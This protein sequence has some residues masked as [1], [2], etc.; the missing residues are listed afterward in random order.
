MKALINRLLASVMLLLVVVCLTASSTPG[1]DDNGLDI[2]ECQ[3]P[4]SCPF[5]YTCIN[6]PGGYYCISPD[7][8]VIEGGSSSEKGYTIVTNDCSYKGTVDA[9]GCVTVLGIRKFVGLGAGAIYR[10]T[11]TNVAT[12]CKLNGNFLCTPYS[13]AQFWKSLK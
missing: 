3:I 9:D 5:E 7:G 10:K 6:T 4:G 12:N 11:Y 1:Y 8:E 13:C 2:D